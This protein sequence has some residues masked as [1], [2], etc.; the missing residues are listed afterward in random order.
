MRPRAASAPDLGHTLD[1]GLSSVFPAPWPARPCMPIWHCM[2]AEPEAPS[3]TLGPRGPTKGHDLGGQ[4]T[5]APIWRREHAGPAAQ[6]SATRSTCA[7]SRLLSVSM[8]GPLACMPIWHCMHE[9]PDAPSSTVGPRAPTTWFG[10][11][12]TWFGAQPNGLGGQSHVLGPNRIVRGLSH[13]VWGPTMGP[14]GPTPLL[15]RHISLHQRAQTLII[16]NWAHPLFR[17]AASSFCQNW[18]AKAP[19]L[20]FSATL[21]HSDPH[22]AQNQSLKCVCLSFSAM[23]ALFHVS[24]HSKIDQQ[25]TDVF[26]QIIF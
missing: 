4:L 2:H 25:K 17:L 13:S 24:R 7:S 5:C 8:A 26:S 3:S 15:W 20:P 18:H 19:L 23:C 14:G 11:P 21:A 9:E 16:G 6:I 12:I 10:G 1:M 22:T